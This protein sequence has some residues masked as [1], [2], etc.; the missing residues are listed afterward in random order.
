MINSRGD[1]ASTGDSRAVTVNEIN[2]GG[3]FSFIL[4]NVNMA[5]YAG[6]GKDLSV[7]TSIDFVPR[8]RNP[9][10]PSS[11]FMNDYIDVRWAFAE[12]VVPIEAFQLSLFVGKFD[13]V[14]GI[15]YR[16]QQASDRTTVTPS[17]ICRYTC[18]R[19]TGLKARARFFGEKLVIALAATNG[20]SVT[21]YFPFSNS[22]VDYNNFKTMSGRISSKI[23]V[24]A[25]WEIGISGSIGAQ[26][27]QTNDKVLHWH[28][29]ADM[30]LVIRYFEFMAEYVRGKA[31]GQTDL[32][33]GSQ[34]CG[35]SPCLTY[36]GAY[37]LVSYAVF[38]WLTPY[39]RADWREAL[40][41]AGGTG[42]F[43]YVTRMVRFTAGLKFD[44]GQYVTVKGEFTK[45]I[46]VGNMPQVQNDVATSSF[47]VKY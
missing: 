36:Q 25:G 40:H 27:L 15:E 39:F 12:Y 24:G 8:V 14:L 6:L 13:P 26:D 28:V 38:N 4:N 16:S 34:Q 5:L 23:P 7:S 18:G 43:V 29:G 37:G 45:A 11:S 44:I 41:I 10:I 17:L 9:S 33:A 22:E 46:E 35:I 32:A 20:S 19:P 47:I 1:P 30:K 42:A 31:N 2:N 3:K 21:E